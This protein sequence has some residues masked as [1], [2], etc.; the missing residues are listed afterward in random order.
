[1]ITEIIISLKLYVLQKATK[2]GDMLIQDSFYNLLHDVYN[3]LSLHR[4]ID[5]TTHS[6]KKDFLLRNTT[7]AR[8]YIATNFLF[9]EYLYPIKHGLFVSKDT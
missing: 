7:V 5:A 8:D 1:M 9:H 6:I 2:K 3:I 4:Y